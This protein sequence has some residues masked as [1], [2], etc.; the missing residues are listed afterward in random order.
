MD[1]HSGKRYRYTSIIHA[2]STHAWQCL[3]ISVEWHTSLL[4]CVCACVRACVCVR[5]III[6]LHVE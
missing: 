5:V 2:V 1:S 3:N 6:V 4:F